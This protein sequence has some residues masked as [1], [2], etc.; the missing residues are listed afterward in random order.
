MRGSEFGDAGGCSEIEE[1]SAVLQNKVP[2]K[3][4]YAMAKAAAANMLIR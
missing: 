1:R 3:W 2:A 4:R